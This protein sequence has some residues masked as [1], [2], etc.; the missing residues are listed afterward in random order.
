MKP[1]IILNV[2]LNRY[3]LRR[4]NLD[5]LILLFIFSLIVYLNIGDFLPFLKVN[6]EDIGRN[7]N[8]LK[9]HH[10]FQKHLNNETYREPIIH[11]KIVRK[12][13]GKF[14]TSKLHKDSYQR[15]C[16]KKLQKILVQK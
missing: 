15:K 1:F 7:L 2:C 13:I 10:W 9:K 12:A 6:E 4:G 11:D 3:F 16:Q 8:Q 14:N 5:I